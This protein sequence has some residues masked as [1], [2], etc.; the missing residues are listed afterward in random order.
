VESVLQTGNLEPETQKPKPETRNPIPEDNPLP[1]LLLS[2]LDASLDAS[3][4]YDTG[5][6]GPVSRSEIRV[7]D[8]PPL[9]DDELGPA[10]METSKE[11]TPSVIAGTPLVPAEAVEGSGDPKPE[12]RNPKPE[13]EA[14]PS[15]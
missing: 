3:G 15:G 5:I 12:I 8:L 9:H 2:P 1:S 4:Q 6:L 10:K 7:E 11:I 13:T 14:K